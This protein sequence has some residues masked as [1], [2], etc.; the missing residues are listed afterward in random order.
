M[1]AIGKI[2]SWGP[3]LVAVIG[4]ALFAFIA[5]ELFRSCESTRNQER[6]QIG[7]VLGKKIDVQEFQKL[8]DEY[9]DVIKMTQGRDNLTDQELNQVKDMVWQNYVQGE[10]IADEAEKLGLT[11]TD[12]ELQNMI[13]EGT[14]PMLLQTP[15]TNQQTGRFDASAL[16][17]FLAE[18]KKAQQTGG[19]M[20]EQYNS[21]YNY[22]KFIEKNLRVQTLQQKYQA[23]LA[24]CILSNPK[25][26]E[27]AYRA[28]NEESDI[29]LATFAYSTINDKDVQLSDAD[30]KAKYEELK[31][32]FK[33][34]EETRDVKYVDFQVLPSTADRT[35]LN[36][37]VNDA[38]AKLAAADDPSEVVRKSSSLV[39]YLGIPQ[40]KAAFPSD[41][42]QQLDSIAV[43]S[44]TTVKENKADNTLNVVK[45]ISKQQLP[46]SVEFRA[47]QVAAEDAATAKKTADSIYTA[48]QGGA[49][50]E[51]IAKK[52][53]QTGEKTWI[54]SNQ[55]QNAPS[56]DK[57]TKAYISALSNAAVNSLTNLP[58]TNGNIILQ[59]TDR[60]A[61][62]TKYLAAVIKKSIDFSKDTYSA[63]YN[64]FSQFVSE[65]QTLEAMEKNA[66]KYGYKV[67]ER[68]SIS[69]AEHYVVNIPATR[70]AMKWLFEAKKGEISPLYECGNNDHL[71]VLA[72]TNVNKKGYQ[73][74][75]N[76]QVN[77]YVR[78][79]ALNDK[80]AEML[81]KKAAGVKS[82][83]EAMKA[84]AKVDSVNQVTFAAPVFIAE[85]GASEPALSG[86]VAAT[87]A[88]KF[89][90][91]P[92][93][94]NAGV[95]LFQVNKKQTRAG[96]KYDAKTAEQ[97]QKQRM[98]QYAGQFMRDLFQKANITDNRYLFF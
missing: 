44:T 12:Q 26:A 42:A 62:V 28:E 64:K 87:D 94:G 84:G 70:E 60:R 9:T 86:A 25:Q 88:G 46:D 51:A 22:W 79:Q 67:Q 63:A 85:T 31:P 4:L 81:M 93:K 43:G 56:M 83:A 50:F 77:E 53:G 55:Y 61:M 73:T 37:T 13:N 82:L 75:D 89:S 80:K 39:S 7:E 91:A 23:L 29:Q 36:K 71:L 17:K 1:A 72:L 16:K 98:M 47:I 59:V 54:T 30:V 8:M 34:L 57:D 35:A 3:I 33:L 27:M 95:Y 14:N 5:E 90:A 40:T 38:A 21:I 11:V 32:S 96:V 97:T 41:I 48:L 6:Q 52:Y 68:N 19:Q 20:A 15:F 66:Q 74:L 69:N 2:R 10:L 49:D 58:M 78:Q 24:G 18:Y 92:V 45:L 76:K 65:N